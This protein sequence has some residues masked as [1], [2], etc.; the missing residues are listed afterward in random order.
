MIP[1]SPLDRF[2]F[3]VLIAD[4]GGTNARFAVIEGPGCGYRDLGRTPTRDHLDPI[5]AIRDFAL[6]RSDTRPRT[7][8]LALAAAIEGEAIPFTNCPWVVEP[9]RLISELG[10]DDVV[11][12][13]D[14]EAQ[15]LALPSLH[16][17]DLVAL[18]GGTAREGATKAV[19]GPGTGLGV[20]TL[21]HSRGT[22]IPMPGE[23]GHVTLAP[24]GA[25]E[26]TI[27]HEVERRHGRIGAEVLISGPGL[28]RLH[29]AIRAVD[30]LAPQD[31]DPAALQKA[32]EAG[33]AS[34]VEA[35]SIFVTALGRLC[36]DVALTVLPQGGVY[37]AGGISPRILP[38]L[39]DGRFRAAFEDKA[40]FHELIASISTR[41]IV[42][43]LPAFVGLTAFACAPEA[44]AVDLDRRRWR[45]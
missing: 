12:I 29:G 35:F 31:L 14:F 39:G 3:P 6:A 19:I 18:G 43:P 25:R 44:Y 8:I 26:E 5:A 28:V 1:S 13:N 22:W 11:L 10:F 40:P 37:I 17:D 34:A 30:G 36:G 41:V 7:A 2:T 20:A 27:W 45:G 4:I 9:K 21:V 16:G 24:R 38:L 33:E 23:G 15:A 32:A 42:H